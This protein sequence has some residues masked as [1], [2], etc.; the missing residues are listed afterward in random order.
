MP[1]A[2]ILAFLGAAGL[3]LSCQSASPDPGAEAAIAGALELGAPLT[4]RVE[5]GPLDEVAA[6][7][8]LTFADATRR[9]V[10]TDPGLQAALAQVRIALADA[11]QARLLPNPILD[12]VLRFGSGSP[13]IELG[14]GQDLVRTLQA[15]ERAS[16]ADDRLRESAAGAV[17]VALD[18]AAAVQEQYVMA[19]AWDRLVP[20]LEARVALL[21]RLADVA[22][23]RLDSGEG[24]RGDLTALEAQRVDLE[25]EVAEA[26]QRQRHERLRLARLI[27][28][29]SGAAA[30]TLDPWSPPGEELAAENLWIE[31]ALQ[32][33]PE[34]L[35]LHWRF[36]ALGGDQ[37]LLGLLPWEGGEAG[38]RAEK[39]GDW[40]LG[41][42][43]STPLPLFDQGQA[44]ADR[45]RAER[46]AVSHELTLARRKVVEE[47]RLAYQ[48][49]LAGRAQLE[50]IR[51]ELLPLQERR[52]QATEDVYR[53][54]SDL[55]PLLLA[56]QDLRAAQ[57]LAIL[58]ERQTALA[59]VQLHRSVGGAAAAAGVHDA[60]VVLR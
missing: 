26:K 28:E 20:E 22:G 34:L 14:L 49:I 40:S 59:L 11:D 48:D 21:R 29:P 58:T 55:T 60:S 24:T 37:E 6:G 47:V 44:R 51:G 53:V 38:V 41:P 8:G 19:Q 36:S 42:A 50:R 46:I 23:N 7:P 27:G 52:R 17:R 30:W 5:G 16:A 25:V 13:Q 33:R 12:V 1:Y 39:D 54:E 45:L 31:T 3:G 57:T 35:A 18:V 15:G 56:E 9:A 10:T 32:Q 2:R 4:F 43:V